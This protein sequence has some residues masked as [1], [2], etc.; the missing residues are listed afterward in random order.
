MNS[1]TEKMEDREQF[2]K[3][4]ETIKW[5]DAMPEHLSVGDSFHDSVNDC[6]FDCLPEIPETDTDE[7]YICDVTAANQ[8]DGSPNVVVQLNRVED[9]E[10]S[11][12]VT[13]I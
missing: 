12:T 7:F 4:V 1:R 5:Y 6:I 8:A 9:G 3:L 11:H 2:D 10:P 13:F